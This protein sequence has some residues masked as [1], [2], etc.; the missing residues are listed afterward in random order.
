MPR[1]EYILERLNGAKVFSKIDL[2]SGYHQVRIVKDG[3]YKTGFR[4]ERGQY[5]FVVMPFG[6]AGAVGTFNRLMVGR[7]SDMIG[8]FVFVFLDDILIFSPS[9]EQHAHDLERVLARLAELQ[10]YVAAKKS[11]FF[12][13]EIAYLGYIISSSGVRLDPSKVDQ[14]RNWD[15]PTTAYEVRSF[16]GLCQAYSSHIKDFAR[17]AAPMT[18]LLKGV[19][20]RRQRVE[21]TEDAVRAFSALKDAVTAAPCLIL[22]SW[23]DPFDVWTDASNV[24]IS[25]VLQ[26]HNRPVAFFSRKLNSAERNYSVYDKELLSVIHALKHWKHFLYGRD[27]AVRIDQSPSPQVALVHAKSTL[28]RASGSMVTVF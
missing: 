19:K 4:T 2:K 27:F 28:E 16:L 3:I 18:D 26:Q 17:L 5:E 13:T 25:A 10:L 20:T 8:K 23:D 15:L 12:L 22:A 9:F 14:V 21:L 6:L 24:A 7:F 1:I 11:E